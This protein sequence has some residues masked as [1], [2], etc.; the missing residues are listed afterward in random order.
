MNDALAPD[1]LAALAML[2]RSERD[3]AEQALAAAIVAEDT[4][5]EQLTRTRAEGDA[6]RA[7]A[8]R[9]LETARGDARTGLDFAAIDGLVRDARLRAAAQA[10]ALAA[11]TAGLQSAVDGREAA[12]AALAA[13]EAA[14]TAVE[15]RLERERARRAAAREARAE[16]EAD[17][18][19]AERA[20]R[21]RRN[22][23]ARDPSA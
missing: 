19:A 2:R 22:L 15:R 10:E 5:R 1:P 3:A 9:R 6:A 7:A 20:H 18:R 12:R 11:A 16:L 14:T 21:N 8:A 13:A 4:A 17:E 23:D